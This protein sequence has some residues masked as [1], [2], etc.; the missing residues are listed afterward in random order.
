MFLSSVHCALSV[1]LPL[2]PAD[3]FSI[4]GEAKKKKKSGPPWLCPI[5]LWKLGTHFTLTFPHGRNCWLRVMPL[6]IVPLSLF[7]KLAILS[8]MT[9]L[10]IGFCSLY[11]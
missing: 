10:E 9:T 8:I 5:Q 7:C 11:G 1:S 6:C 3:H 4:L 2:S